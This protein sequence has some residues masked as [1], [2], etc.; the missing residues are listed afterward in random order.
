[1]KWHQFLP[2]SREDVF[3]ALPFALRRAVIEGCQS[4]A[5]SMCRMNLNIITCEV[6]IH[7]TEC[8]KK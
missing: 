5:K 6:C 8:G 3:N 1:M 4:N 7:Y 2:K